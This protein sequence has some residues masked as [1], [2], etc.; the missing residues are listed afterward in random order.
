MPDPTSR[1]R[2]SSWVAWSGFGETH[3][4]WKQAGVQESSGRVSGRTQTARYQFPTFRL[5][6]VLLQTSRI[7]LCKTSPDPVRFWPSGS[8]QVLAKWIRSG[9]GQVDPVRKHA[10]S[11]IIRPASGQCFHPD[12]DWIGSSM[13]TGYAPQYNISR[14]VLNPTQIIVHRPTLPHGG[15]MVRKPIA[16]HT[17]FKSDP[18]P[19]PDP[20]PNHRPGTASNETSRPGAQRGTLGR[21]SPGLVP[22]GKCLSWTCARWKMSQLDLCQVENVSVGLVPGGKCLSWT[23]ARWKMSQLDLCQVENVS[24]GLVPGG[25]CLSWT[26]TRWKTS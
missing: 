21:V 5:G 10:G 9:F 3:L 4:V 24:V 16:Q 22:G 15:Q 18:D 23:C 11:R 14:S 20:E 13:F 25:K 17:V 6:F 1:T 8:A 19:D 26:C 12:P 2:F 7:I